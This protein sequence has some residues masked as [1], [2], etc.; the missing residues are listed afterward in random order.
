MSLRSKLTMSPAMAVRAV[1]L[2]SA[3]L[4]VGAY[5]LEYGMGMK[6]CEL[7]W[8]QRY[9]HWALLV[10]A[11]LAMIQPRI[12]PKRALK[13]LMG[14]AVVGIAVAVYHSLVEARVLIAGCAAG[15]G[16]A[17]SAAEMMAL[18][19]DAP[20]PACD[21]PNNLLW[22]SLPQWNVLAQGLLVVFILFT[23]KRKTVART[24][25]AQPVKPTATKKV[26]PAKKTLAKKVP[27]KKAKPVVKGKAKKVAK[28]KGR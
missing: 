4:I 28:K 7:C 24:V 20:V 13:F 2:F 26:L 8:L 6:P 22:L 23:L 25:K 1:A 17:G 10:I 12:E 15:Q 19:S 16:L 14:L 27:A 5:A 3:L 21:Q 9:V 18:L 11:L